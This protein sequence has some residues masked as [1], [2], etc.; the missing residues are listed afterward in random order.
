MAL[1]WCFI[2]GVRIEV[3]NL[4]F[5]AYFQNGPLY[6]DEGT[7]Y[8]LPNT[9]STTGKKAG[10]AGKT[11]SDSQLTGRETSVEHTETAAGE[12]GPSGASL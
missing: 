2:C 3:R 7:K 9:G 8:P 5:S 12:R 11:Q 4:I 10:I 1:N 6:P